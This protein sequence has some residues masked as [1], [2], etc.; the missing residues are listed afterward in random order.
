MSSKKSSRK[1]KEKRK[2]VEEERHEIPLNK[3]PV[4]DYPNSDTRFKYNMPT[5]SEYRNYRDFNKNIG[6]TRRRKSNRRH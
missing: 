3:R 5:Y 1:R 4:L 2:F 6:G